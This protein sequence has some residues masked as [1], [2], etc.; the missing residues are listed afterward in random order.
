MRLAPRAAGKLPMRPAGSPN[1][2]GALAALLCLSSAAVPPVCAQSLSVTFR[3]TRTLG[4]TAVDQFGAPFTVAGLSGI[5]YVGGDEF[6]AVMDN[7]NKIVR[8][9]IALASDGAIASAG[10]LG[11]VTLLESRDFEGIAR[12][13]AGGATVW[14]SEEG[15]PAVHEFDLTTGAR[16]RTL[17]TPSIFAERRDN[18]GFES[19]SRFDGGAALWTANEEALLSDGPRSTAT[20]GTLVRLLRFERS[21]DEYLP[22]PQYAYLTQ[23]LHGLAVTDARSGVSDLVWLPSR[24]LLVLERSF[25]FA[26]PPFQNRIYE[27]TLSSAT[28]VRTFDHLP[29]PGVT[30]AAKRLLWSGGVNNMEG[31]A[32][33]PALAGGGFA[34]LGV[35]DDGDPISAN[36]IVAF[37][38]TGPVADPCE[39]ARAGDANCDGA[40]D[41]ADIDAFVL[42]LLDPAAWRDTFACDFLCAGDVNEDGAV[43]AGDIDGFVRLLLGP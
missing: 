18:F 33:G 22:G 31:L 35:V 12:A 20:Q 8:L 13:D 30:L 7:S 1:L 42:A 28:D 32:L 21:G 23:P 29:D 19:L 5:T 11:G 9:E 37:Q 34:L 16:L 38:L 27:V 25:A 26:F 14:L 36:A 24:R 6:L 2:Q 15:T 4:T 17:A 3:G 10:I 40:L 43:D 41:N 39:G